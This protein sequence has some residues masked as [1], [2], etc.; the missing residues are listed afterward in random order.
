MHGKVTLMYDHATQHSGYYLPES[1]TVRYQ[2]YSP[3]RTL[4]IQTIPLIVLQSLF[5]SLCPHVGGRRGEEI[6]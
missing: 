1:G 5:S 2:K 6:E 3:P 4:I